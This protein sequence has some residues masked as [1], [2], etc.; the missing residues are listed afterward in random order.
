MPKIH[1]R[2]TQR[3]YTKLYIDTK[4]RREIRKQYVYQQQGRGKR[5]KD[6]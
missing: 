1:T 3:A 4:A 6:T 5:A 2:K